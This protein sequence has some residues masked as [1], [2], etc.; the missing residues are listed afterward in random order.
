MLSISYGMLNLEHIIAKIHHY[1]SIKLLISEYSLGIHSFIFLGMISRESKMIYI[2]QGVITNGK[3]FLIKKKQILQNP[4]F[5]QG[6]KPML[7]GYKRWVKTC[8]GQRKPNTGGGFFML[9][10]GP[11]N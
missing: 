1:P 4:P 2:W 11:R 10:V 9:D 7:K 8:M 6:F 3:N 5:L